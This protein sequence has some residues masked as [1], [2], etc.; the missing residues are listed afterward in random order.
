[1]QTQLWIPNYEVR[2]L[3]VCRSLKRFTFRCNYHLNNTVLCSSG[4]ELVMLGVGYHHAGV[5]L[6]DRKL[7]E[8]AF[9]QADLPVLCESA[10]NIIIKFTHIPFSPY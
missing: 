10:C 6:S 9:T 1:M 8:K 5:E 4:P 3:F 7:I 2:C